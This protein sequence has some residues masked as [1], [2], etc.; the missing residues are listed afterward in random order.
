M[1]IVSVTELAVNFVQFGIKY[2]YIFTRDLC[3]KIVTFA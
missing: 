2:M 1:S 3:V